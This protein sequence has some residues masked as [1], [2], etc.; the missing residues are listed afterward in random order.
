LLAGS[1]K[2]CDSNTNELFA[3]RTSPCDRGLTE[4]APHPACFLQNWRECL[5]FSVGY[6]WC[7]CVLG[8]RSATPLLRRL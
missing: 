3:S 6:A 8:A 4:C 2:N 5:G 7:S 1:E